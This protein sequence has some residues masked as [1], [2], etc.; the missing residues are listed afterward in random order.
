MNSGYGEGS[1]GSGVLWISSYAEGASCHQ[2]SF[3]VREED[4][5]PYPLISL[6]LIIKQ[7]WERLRREMDQ[8]KLYVQVQKPHIHGGSDTTR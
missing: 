5:F 3:E 8:D 2:D 6:S 7:T 1:I 4:I